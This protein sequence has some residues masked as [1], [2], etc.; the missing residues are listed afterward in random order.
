MPRATKLLTAP[1][2]R[3]ALSA[4]LTWGILF[5]TAARAQSV[6]D[7]A[8]RVDRYYNRLS[9]M[10]AAFTET[11]SGA[12]IDRTES[13]TLLLKKPGRMRWDYASP[14]AKLFVADGSTAWFYV[15][16]ERQARKADIKKLDDLRS[17]LRFL[18]GKTRLRKE[19][20]GLSIATDVHPL[21]PDT[22]I[23]RG[24]P[25]GMEDRVQQVQIEVNPAGQIIR[26]RVEEVD[27]ATTEFRFTNIEPNAPVDSALFR[28]KPPDGVEVV[29][30]SSL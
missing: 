2:V 4:A 6:S 17:P 23:L 26:I 18:L 3:A 29:E 19:L 9:S 30:E 7:V 25:K 20:N 10:K 11:Y 27:G 21:N 28:F 13:G 14:R 15:P 22:T 8:S 5:A 12:G 1:R 24:I 16:G